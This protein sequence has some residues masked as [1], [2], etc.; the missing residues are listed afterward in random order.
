MK[1]TVDQSD[2]GSVDAQPEMIV[3]VVSPT[4]EALYGSTGQISAVS[5]GA[6][7]GTVL[8]AAVGL[9]RGVM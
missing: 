9:S 7:E 2:E 1:R 8:D 6:G 3:P 4:R 5:V